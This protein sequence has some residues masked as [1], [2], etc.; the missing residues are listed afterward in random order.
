MPSDGRSVIV[1]GAPGSQSLRRH[2][3]LLLENRRK[4]CGRRKMGSLGGFVH[5]PWILF[6]GGYR[7]R[8][9]FETRRQKRRRKRD[10]ARD[11]GVSYANATITERQSGRKLSSKGYPGC[12]P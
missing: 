4:S 11:A 10:L 2:G 12:L 5:L 7:I 1:I 6:D 8:S 3:S 9:I